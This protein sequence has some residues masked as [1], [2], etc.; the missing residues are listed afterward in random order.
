MEYQRVGFVNRSTTQR[1]MT[2]YDLSASY[3]DRQRASV[4]PPPVVVPILSC[5][6]DPYRNTPLPPAHNDAMYVLLRTIFYATTLVTGS[7]LFF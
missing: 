7:C 5:D 6:D 1:K 3:W 2:D 4:P